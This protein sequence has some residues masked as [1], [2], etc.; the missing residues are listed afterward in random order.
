MLNKHYITKLPKFELSYD[1]I[2]H[3]KVF[4]DIFMLIPKGN[5]VLA[6]FTYE[7]ENNIYC[8]NVSCIKQF[9]SKQFKKRCN[10]GKNND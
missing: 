10:Y 9:F 4:S 5:K 8:F 7:N 6:W 2:L 1:T 3:K